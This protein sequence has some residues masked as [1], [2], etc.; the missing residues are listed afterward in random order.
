MLAD[1]T[2]FNDDRDKRSAFEM[3]NKAGGSKN[4]IKA[5]KFGQTYYR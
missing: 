1:Y 4:P 3:A 5:R 2:A